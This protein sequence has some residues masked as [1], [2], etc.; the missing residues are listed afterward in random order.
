VLRVVCVS[1]RGGEDAVGLGECPVVRDLADGGDL[2]DKLRVKIDGRT[3]L[4]APGK[5]ILEVAEENGIHIPTL[6]HLDG[7]RDVGACRLCIV[8]LYGQLVTSCTTKVADGM[9][10][11]TQTETVRA[12]RRTI[13]EL[14]F[15]EGNH[16]CSFCVSNGGCELQDL[17]CELGMHSVRVPYTYRRERVDATHPRFLIDRD[18]CVLCGRC[19]RVCQEV[20]GAHTWGF[21]ERGVTA[22]VITDLAVPWGT[23]ESCTSCGKCVEVCPTGA[24]AQKGASNAEMRKHPELVA[25]LTERRARG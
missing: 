16:V 9:E 6:C 18:R 4:A 23:A 24:I 3:I 12:Y 8:D 10:I 25:E 5:T 14:L 7:L 2:V 17:A 22:R 13:L 19:V 15:A 11:G 20:E 21:A 1:G